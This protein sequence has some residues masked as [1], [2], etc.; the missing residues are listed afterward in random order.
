PDAY[1]KQLEDESITPDRTGAPPAPNAC[2]RRDR[3]DNERGHGRGFGYW[4]RCKD[5]PHRT[6]LK[7]SQAEETSVGGSPTDEMM[8]DR[9]SAQRSQREFSPER[10]RRDDGAFRQRGSA[11]TG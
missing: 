6:T 4:P 10:K 2:S 11:A 5:V 8:C 9:N 3:A 7:R 1:A